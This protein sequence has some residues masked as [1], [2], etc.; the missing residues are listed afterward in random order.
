MSFFNPV[1]PKVIRAGGGLCYGLPGETRCHILDA[2]DTYGAF[3]LCTSSLLPNSF[4][5]FSTF[6]PE[7]I[8]IG[9]GTLT[10]RLDGQ[11]FTL[12]PEDVALFP[13]GVEGTLLCTSQEPG[14]F[15]RAS[16]LQKQDGVFEKAAI[17]TR[18]IGTKDGECLEAF[19]ER[20]RVVLASGEMQN[21]FCLVEMETPPLGGW[22]LHLHESQNRAYFIRA[23]RY[24]F[25]LDDARV[26]A[27]AG[28]TIFVPRCIPQS[29]RVVS[30]QPG[31]LF[32]LTVEGGFDDSLREVARIAEQILLDH[33]RVTTQNISALGD[34]H[35]FRFLS[36]IL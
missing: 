13:S 33:G 1:Q 11:T 5:S 23:G 8:L 17:P 29:F 36:S 4:C 2:D 10:L 6:G 19:G 9:S 16:I 12:Q 20:T 28:D 34:C 31:R 22:P 30:A 18:I 3:G 7:W 21:Q 27:T 15:F 35:G 14:I 25:C 32:L 24:E 26:L